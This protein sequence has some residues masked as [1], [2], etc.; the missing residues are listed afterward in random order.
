MLDVNHRWNQLKGHWDNKY[1]RFQIICS[2]LWLL[3]YEY[4][5]FYLF[6]VFCFKSI[7]WFITNCNS[8]ADIKHL[9]IVTSLQCYSFSE[10]Q[11]IILQKY[12]EI[13]NINHG[14]LY[15]EYC[16]NKIIL[17]K[18]TNI[19]ADNNAN[20]T[21]AITSTFHSLI[22]LLLKLLKTVWRV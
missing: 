13:H 18:N 10:E 11:L 22:F 12:I 16:F 7:I 2:S 9:E 21:N 14:F 20:H 15:H 4:F 19:Y 17:Y 5:Y 3:S 8:E 6:F 1:D